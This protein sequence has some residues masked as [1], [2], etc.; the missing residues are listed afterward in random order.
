MLIQNKFAVQGHR[1]LREGRMGSGFRDIA[2]TQAK[3]SEDVFKKKGGP[4]QA[5]RCPK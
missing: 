4:T 5:L 3:S 2:Q 1:D